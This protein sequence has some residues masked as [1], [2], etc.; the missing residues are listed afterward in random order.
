MFLFQFFWCLD[1]SRHH[2]SPSFRTSEHLARTRWPHFNSLSLYVPVF[3]IKSVNT[4]LSH[5]NS[6]I[7]A[8]W[9]WKLPFL[10]KI[11]SLL[12]FRPPPRCHVHHYQEFSKTHRTI[13]PFE[14]AW[15]LRI[16]RR[17]TCKW[18]SFFSLFASV[19]GILSAAPKP[20]ASC[21]R[22]QQDVSNLIARVW[23]R[24]LFWCGFESNVL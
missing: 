10:P 15:I 5:R 2:K 1:S 16:A 4:D 7:V 13:S 9:C 17:G 18:N 6:R 3:F 22:S 12:W 20:E 23:T 14:R 19:S 11:H 21:F 24:N 8:F